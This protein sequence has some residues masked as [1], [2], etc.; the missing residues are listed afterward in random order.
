MA[1]KSV[2]LF[3]MAGNGPVV[4]E[5]LRLQKGLTH[6]SLQSMSGRTSQV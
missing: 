2:C 3:S 1:F 6:L 4:L 5:T